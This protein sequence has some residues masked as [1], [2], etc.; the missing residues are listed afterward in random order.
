MEQF[1][2]GFSEEGFFGFSMAFNYKPVGVERRR[3]C[4]QTI[5]RFSRCL[6]CLDLVNK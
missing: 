3:R 4:L 1:E 5:T 2:E 6:K